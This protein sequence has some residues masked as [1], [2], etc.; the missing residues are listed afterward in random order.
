MNN[1]STE[2]FLSIPIRPGLEINA[3]DQVFGLGV[4]R[5]EKNEL[6]LR[7]PPYSTTVWKY[8]GNVD[9]SMSSWVDFTP[10]LSADYHQIELFLPDPD[11]RV[12]QLQLAG[13]F[14][15]WTATDYQSKR[16]GDTVFVSIPLKS[17]SYQ[18]KLVV[19]GGE[20]I[21]DP[22]AEDFLIDPYGG[23]NSVL[24]VTTD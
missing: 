22:N 7:L 8:E 5:L 6:W 16:R 9:P 13:D 24:V 21:A 4:L 17:G 20:W 18:Y 11:G 12:T 23:E 19:N 15:N 10:R 1:A 14:N 3:A 2:E